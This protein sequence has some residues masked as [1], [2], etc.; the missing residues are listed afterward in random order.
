[1]TDK[2]K[3]L[4]QEIMKENFRK[5]KHKILVLSGKGGVGKSTVSV[6]T[7]YSLKMKGFR[8]G[9]LDIDL[10]G[11]SIAKMTGIEDSR[12]EGDESGL[13]L[14]IKTKDG[15]DVISISPMLEK[16]DTP[17]IWRGP[18]KM[19]AI[20]EFFDSVNWS[21]LDYLIIDSPPGTGDEPLTALQIIEGIDGVVIVTT[22]QDVAT[23]DVSRSISFVKAM[24]KRI[25][26]L[27]ENMSYFICT[28]CGEKH[29]I[30]KEGGAEMLSKK[31]GIE[32]LGR[33]PI[34]SD[35]VDLADNGKPYV[36]KKPDSL[37]S[38][39]YLLIVDRL[40]EKMNSEK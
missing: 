11:P 33:I 34:E 26:G 32:I 38:K 30:F 5:I 35:M 40:I 19:K 23:S 2:D 28:K 15:V 21:E 24:N 3:E 4:K 7:A 16:S 13:L 17:V 8:V 12:I 14:P 9:I 27:V 36:L 31:Y 1:M 22:P 29:F 37:V 25:L 10:H 6:N 39:E 20:Q 18:L